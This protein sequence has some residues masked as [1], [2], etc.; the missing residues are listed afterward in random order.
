VQGLIARITVLIPLLVGVVVAIA[1]D[2]VDDILG[3][4]T[5]VKDGKI[6][7]EEQEAIDTRRSNRRWAAL[8]AIAG[9]APYFTVE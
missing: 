2:L 1:M 7:I 3:I 8:R 9:K 6:T 5:A 4:V